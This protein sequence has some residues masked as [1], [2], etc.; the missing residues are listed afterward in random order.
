MLNLYTER[1][2]LRRLT[3]EDTRN[4]FESILNNKDTLHFLDWP[5]CNNL[6]EAQSFVRRLIE[7]IEK[8][9]YY[10]WVIEEKDTNS[11]VGC[12]SICGA[13]P[14]KRMVEIEYVA[15]SEHRGKGYMPEANKRV[16]EH[17][18][19]DCNIYRVEAVCNIENEASARVMEKSG[20]K[21]EGILRGR[22]LNLNAEGNPG[23]LKMYSII[24]SDLN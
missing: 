4:I 8:L 5:Y 16:I 9:N 21:F 19:N 22:A 3:I 24:P 17:L 14:E 18:I 15:S 1:L 7:N 23:D 20:M 10:F 11:F 12:I 13:I 2:I 6:D